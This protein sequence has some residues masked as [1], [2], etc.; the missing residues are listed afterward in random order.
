MGFDR[1]DFFKTIAVTTGSLAGVSS[2]TAT[3]SNGLDADRFGVLSDL[4]YCLGCRHCEWAC[5]EANGL[6]NQPLEVFSDA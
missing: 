3:E 2:L 4:T 6:P 5:N 1:R